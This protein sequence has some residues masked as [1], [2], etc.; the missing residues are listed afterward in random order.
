MRCCVLKIPWGVSLSCTLTHG[1]LA[2]SLKFPLVLLR[3]PS[4]TKGLHLNTWLNGS[5]EKRQGILIYSV[6]IMMP[7][8]GMFIR[9]WSRSPPSLPNQGSRQGQGP[10]NAFESSQTFNQAPDQ[11]AKYLPSAKCELVLDGDLGQKD[12]QEGGR[13]I[14]WKPKERQIYCDGYLHYQDNEVIDWT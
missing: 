5:S 12:K 3:L 2:T 10:E 9:S 1:V 13:H 4:E 11:A 8:I 14:I 7:W 6:E